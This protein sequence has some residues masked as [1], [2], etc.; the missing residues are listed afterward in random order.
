MGKIEIIKEAAKAAK[1]KAPEKKEDPNEV[2]RKLRGLRHKVGHRVHAGLAVKGGAGY[3]GEV[4]KIDD[5]HTYIKIDKNRVVKAPHRLVTR[6]EVEVQEESK[7]QKKERL[8]R[9]AARET[10]SAKA[11]NELENKI[12]DRNEKSKRR[13]ERAR[14]YHQEETNSE[15]RMKVSNIGRPNDPP[16]NSKK[17]VL[18]KTLQI[19]RSVKEE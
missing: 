9:E 15:N 7:E 11:Y 4:V 14:K 18:H 16:V 13:H 3:K 1:K 17:S 8:K 10:R 12:E 5:N 6:E 2:S 19:L